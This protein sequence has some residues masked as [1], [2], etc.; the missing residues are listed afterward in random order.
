MLYIKLSE[1]NAEV[2]AETRIPR[3]TADV[4]SNG[5]PLPPTVSEKVP[6]PTG[7]FC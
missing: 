3:S 2:V 6:K 1:P 5:G 7:V 4:S